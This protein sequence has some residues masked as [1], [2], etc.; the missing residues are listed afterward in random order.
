M[1]HRRFAWLIL[2]AVA[3][4][5]VVGAL[6]NVTLS[7]LQLSAA[8]PYLSLPSDLFLRLI[9]MLIGPLVISTLITGVAGSGGTSALGR[10]GSRTLVLFLISSIATL[11]F[12]F[13]MVELLHPGIHANFSVNLDSV[14]VHTPDTG[15]S[16]VTSLQQIVPR[17]IFEALAT[18][19]ILQIVV[20]SL[21]AGIG[22]AALGPSAAP[23]LKGSRALAALMLKITT[24]VMYL[25]P[26]A[27]FGALTATVATN[28]LGIV[29]SLGK[30]VCGFYLS[31]A[32]LWV[33]LLL[34][35]Y[36]LLGKAI[37]TLVRHMREPILIAFATS[38]SEA[39]YGRTLEQLLRVH[40]PE[41]IANLVLALGYSFNLVGSTMYCVFAFFF[42]A[43]VAGVHY[44]FW[45]TLPI[46]LF[47]L[48]ASKGV[49]GVPRA[50]LVVVT[51]ALTRFGLPDEGLPLIIGV[52]LFLDM[53]RTATNVLGNSIAAAVIAKWDFA[54]E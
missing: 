22:I 48:L 36:L 49:A 12:G 39:A 31:L 35:G 5:L 10:T 9:K 42:V 44:S 23:L 4:G 3:S 1:T 24:Y 38:S 21:L 34:A 29:A 41:Q 40:V 25:A 45:Q 27:V 17:S 6:L 15:L 28:G 14:P 33:L 16:L 8:S 26:F 54:S 37:V 50:S 53:G 46:L 2:F 47:L 13:F 11:A 43:Q 52:D 18:N 20:F 7:A 30:F 19:D 32:L 51:A